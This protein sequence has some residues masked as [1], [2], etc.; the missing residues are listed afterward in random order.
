M[1]ESMGIEKFVEVTIEE[2]IEHQDLIEFI[3]NSIKGN[4]I[5]SAKVR[6]LVEDEMTRVADAE[7]HKE[8]DK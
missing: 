4:K 5:E 1:R 3:I 2:I 7:M 8:L 6:K